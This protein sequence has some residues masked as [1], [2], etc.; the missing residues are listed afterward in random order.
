MCQNLQNC[1]VFLRHQFVLVSA[2][3]LNRLPTVLYIN[4]FHS[5]AACKESVKRLEGSREEL[6][7]SIGRQ[8]IP[9]ILRE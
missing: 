3:G 6:G 5:V 4:V 7:K 8:C 9:F 1:T 2:E